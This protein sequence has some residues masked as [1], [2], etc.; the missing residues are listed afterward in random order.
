MNRWAGAGNGDGAGRDGVP[1]ERSYEER[2]TDL[3]RESLVE[4][5]GGRTARV[6][7]AFLS[8]AALVVAALGTTLGAFGVGTNGGAAG[9]AAGGGVL[10]FAATTM[11]IVGLVAVAAGLW[12]LRGLNRQDPVDEVN[13]RRPSRARLPHSVT[14]ATAW[15]MAAV[16]VG[17]LV[18]VPTWGQDPATGVGIAVACGLLGLIGPTS[19]RAYL[20]ADRDLRDQEAADPALTARLEELN[21]LWVYDVLEGRG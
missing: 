20:F 4:V 8:A 18:L 3:V 6:A 11:A 12:W 9:G 14:A 13:L 10:L 2:R 15:F 21:P 16:V 1:D 7:A 17:L 5:M 19:A